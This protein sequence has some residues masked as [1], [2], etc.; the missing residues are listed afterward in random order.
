LAERTCHIGIT[1]L[2]HK[3]WHRI[4]PL[5][6]ESGNRASVLGQL[7]SALGYF[8]SKAG[9]PVVIRSDEESGFSQKFFR[10]L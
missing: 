4:P 7:P 10:G 2:S 6:C 8:R 1:G 3:T 5:S 9:S